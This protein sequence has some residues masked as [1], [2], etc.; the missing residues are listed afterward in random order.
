L[1]FPS[2]LG[3]FVNRLKGFLNISTLLGAT[4]YKLSNHQIYRLFLYPTDSVDSL[5]ER[6]KIFF[7][8]CRKM[9][10]T[11]RDEEYEKIKKEYSKVTVIAV[12]CIGKRVMFK[13]EL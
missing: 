2:Y 10:P 13:I 12:C 1:T 7:S 11:E 6:Q 4:F 9:K 5:E 3:V 8:N